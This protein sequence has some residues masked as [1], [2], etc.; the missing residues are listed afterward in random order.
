MNNQ[1]KTLEDRVLALERF[2][3][4]VKPTLAEV[5]KQL[6]LS[7]PL[8]NPNSY[9][10]DNLDRQIILYLIEHTS[11]GTTE[12]AEALNLDSPKLIGRHTIGKRIKRLSQISSRDGWNILEFHPELKEGKFRAWWINLEDINVEA[13]KKSIKAYS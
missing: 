3:D 10:K 9:C 13:F 8:I 11:G 7:R 5:E 6:S 12:I 2:A 1:N 4:R